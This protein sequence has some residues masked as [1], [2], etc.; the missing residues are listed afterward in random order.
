M[1]SL[2]WF[3]LY[4]KNQHEKRIACGLSGKLYESFVPTFMNLHKDGRKNE[5]PLFPGY[6]FCR[7][8]ARY[9]LP[10]LSI[11]GVFSIVSAG[12]E[13]ISVPDREIEQI[14]Q[15]LISG[16]APR[17]WPYLG[18]G[19]EVYINSGPLRGMQGIVV[20]ESHERWLLVSIHLLQ[21]S[22]AAKIDRSYFAHDV[23]CSRI[24]RTALSRS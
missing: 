24:Q 3:A 17:P 8:D 1:S 5:L 13:P 12:S 22:V 19:Q 7:F 23:A 11:P 9:K 21:R 6:V 4:V 15:L 18:R 2:P 20:N 16:L 10:V 14:R